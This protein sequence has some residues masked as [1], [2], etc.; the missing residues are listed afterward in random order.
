MRKERIRPKRG[1]RVVVPVEPEVNPFSVIAAL[2][3]YH[4]DE[5]FTPNNLENFQATAAPP[6]SQ[7][8]IEVLRQR[9]LDGQPLWHPSDPVD[10]LGFKGVVEIRSAYHKLKG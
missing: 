8:K 2:A 1:A 3:R 6:G 7:E 9:V 5:D 4:H 10:Y